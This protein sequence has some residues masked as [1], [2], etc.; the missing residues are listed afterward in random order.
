MRRHLWLIGVVVL[1][2]A[3]FAGPIAHA[4]GDGG[5]RL[6]FNEAFVLASGQTLHGRLA[7]VSGSATLQAGSLVQ[8]DVAA[9]GSALTIAGA[10]RGNVAAFGGTVRLAETAIIE[11]DFAA[12]G[13]RVVREPGAVIRG[14]SVGTGRAP[15]SPGLPPAPPARSLFSQ[16]IGWQLGTLGWALFLAVLAVVAVL[17]APRAVGR[18][19][20]A[21]AAEPALTFGLG[22]LTFIVA[23]LGGALLLI[24]CGLGLL[25]WL[26]LGAATL[27]GWIAVGLWVGQ[28]L[29]AAVQ[30][31]PA[32]ALG[33]V[34]LGVV[35]ITILARLPWCVG[36]LF[37]VVVASIGLGAVIVTRFG[38]QPSDAPVTPLSPA[39]PGGP[40]ALELPELPEPERPASPRDDAVER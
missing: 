24:A 15:E 30:V 7:V 26:A 40:L 5:D 20:S 2:L 1:L 28:R 25:V 3:L 13:A 32:S 36:F 10:V 6:V 12:F 14:D 39:I 18:V 23:A 22:L 38:T 33:Q 21:A 4:Q 16:V 11:G 17:L 27:L 34:A 8:Q 31:R 29:L 35:L 9:F 37:S 19:A